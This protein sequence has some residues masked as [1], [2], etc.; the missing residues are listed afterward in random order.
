MSFLNESGDRGRL[1]SDLL[2]TF[3]AIVET[4][5]VTDG[6]KRIFRSQSAASL[7]IK[8]LERVLGR[9]VF[10]RRGRGVALTAA[11][12]ALVPS[13]RRV[14][15][16]IDEA[17]ATIRTEDLRGALRIGIPD[18]WGESVLSAAVARFARQ[19]P[20][21]DLTVRRAFSAGF[22]EALS[23]GELDLAV[24]D[25]EREEPDAVLLG[26]LRR[27]WL[28]SEHH[29]VEGRDPL[30]IAVFDQACAWRDQAMAALD[31]AGR[32]HR[33]VYS[34]ESTSGIVAAV[35]AGIAVGLLPEASLRPGLRA[36]PPPTM[37]EVA[38]SL[39]LLRSRSDGDQEL[40][41]EMTAAIL[42]AFSGSA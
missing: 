8:K 17:V 21:V 16:M 4:G 1:D 11:G 35:D 34:S 12:E 15:E 24:Y 19:F 9:S 6:A 10:E 14:V 18:E 7:Q 5:S 38:D 39:L 41:A 2:R 20:L 31:A 40:I 33:V 25:A 30:P 32:R 36:V 22:P 13:A 26:R 23:R 42:A 27:L 3:L 29:S 37:P 28:S